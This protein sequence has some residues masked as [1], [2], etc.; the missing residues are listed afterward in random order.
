MKLRS[1]IN[2]M[3]PNVSLTK[4]SSLLK[5]ACPK[6]VALMRKYMLDTMS[7]KAG[8]CKAIKLRCIVTIKEH[9]IRV[10]IDL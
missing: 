7:P 6:N 5:K 1:I 8:E 9:E 3:T 2:D 10:K 4:A